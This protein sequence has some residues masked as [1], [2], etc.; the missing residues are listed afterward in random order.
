M[1]IDKRELGVDIGFPALTAAAVIVE[2]G[3]GGLGYRRDRSSQIVLTRHRR[4]QG[5]RLKMDRSMKEI[6]KGDERRKIPVERKHPYL[7]LH[8]SM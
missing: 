4:R 7:P 6:G 2:G 5:R 3:V 8:T 1:L